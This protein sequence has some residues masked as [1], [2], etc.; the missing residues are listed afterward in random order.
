MTTMDENIINIAEEAVEVI[1]EA[2]VVDTIIEPTISRKGSIIAKLVTTA[3]VGASALAVYLV[4]TKEVREEKRKEKYARYLEKSG[5]TVNPPVIETEA[6][7]CEDE[8]V[9]YEGDDE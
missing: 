9:D 8:D 4:K 2:N 1:E 6:F 3:V 5:Y 7:D